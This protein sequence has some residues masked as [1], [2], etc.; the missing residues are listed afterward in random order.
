MSMHKRDLKADDPYYGAWMIYHRVQRRSLVLTILLFWGGA[1]LSVA[2]LQVIW[3]SAP[4]WAWPASVA[5]WAHRGHRRESSRGAVAMPPLRQ[6]ISRDVLGPQRIHATLCAL[7]VTEVGH[8]ARIP[9]HALKPLP[10]K[11]LKLAVR[12][13]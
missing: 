9:S 11:R 1:A 6:V 5:P 8:R 4:T 12:V 10:N 7:S 3:P 2:L 13:D